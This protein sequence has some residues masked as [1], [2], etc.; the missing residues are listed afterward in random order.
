ML[1]TRSL[2]PAKKARSCS[3]PEWIPP[4]VLL[5]ST[6]WNS[7]NQ[8]FHGVDLIQ[9]WYKR[10]EWSHVHY[11]STDAKLGVGETSVFYRLQNG[12]SVKDCK[13]KNIQ[14]CLITRD[15]FL[16]NEY[17]VL[18]NTI[19]HSRVTTSIHHVGSH[20]WHLLLGQS[21]EPNPLS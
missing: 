4:E 14:S 7:I 18:S 3:E 12:L 10:N 21:W 2:K 20:V 11:S 9:P 8:E 15:R 17:S 19:Y 6:S 1:W 5:E 16:T 13:R